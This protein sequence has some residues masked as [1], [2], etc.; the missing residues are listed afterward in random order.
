MTD[1]DSYF[2]KVFK[3]VYLSKRENQA[4]REEMQGHMEEAVESA[5]NNGMT[6]EEAYE[7]ALVS[8]G[9]V[10]EVRHRIIRETY[11]L[12][13]SWFLIS[14]S[15]CFIIF[16][17]SLFV[18]MRVGDV[19]PTTMKPMLTP[20]WVV[21]W[22]N[23]PFPSH[24]QA[25]LGLA[26][27]LF[28]LIYT[29]KRSERIAV[30]LSLAPFFVVW[31]FVRMTHD[32]SLSSMMFAGYPIMEPLGA[33]EMAGYVLLFVVC[34]AIYIWTQ[35]RKVSLTPWIISIS[36]TIWPILRDTVQTAL[37]HITSNPI[38]WGHRYPDFYFLWWS[39]LTILV[40]LIVLGIFVY[41]CRKIDAIRLGKSHAV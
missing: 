4:W 18:Q 33:S 40:R 32:F 2:S 27:V 19:I 29:R 30:F 25:W 24:I 20:K 13:P 34:L 28:M 22:N 5:I 17:V 15:L 7:S 11:G 1:F 37:W 9:S 35:N 21:L 16:L 6:K 38:F 36:L 31:L 39:I 8:F 26:V 10:K 23:N 41:T 3:H 12:S 14:S